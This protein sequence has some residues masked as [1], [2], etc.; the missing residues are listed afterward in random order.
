MRLFVILEWS[1]HHQ[2][3]FNHLIAFATLPKDPIPVSRLLVQTIKQTIYC[4]SLHLFCLTRWLFMDGPI[5]SLVDVMPVKSCLSHKWIQ[6]FY[7]VA[8]LSGLFF[9][10]SSHFNK[11]DVLCLQVY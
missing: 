6:Y 7:F 10:A 4:Y 5:G 11:V 2:R 1:G 8:S 9:G 3:W